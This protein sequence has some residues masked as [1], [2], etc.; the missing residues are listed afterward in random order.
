LAPIFGRYDVVGTWKFHKLKE[1][2]LPS[3]PLKEATMNS[4]RT[5]LKSG[6]LACGVAGSTPALSVTA[7]NELIE[8]N[9]PKKSPEALK[10]GLMTYNLARNWD[11]DTIIQNCTEAKFQHVELRTTHAHGVEVTLNKAERIEVRKRFEDSPLEAISLASAFR[12]HEPDPAVLRENIEGTKEYTLLAA[13]IGALGIRVFPNAVVEGVPMEETFEQIGKALAEV[14]DFAHDHGV[15][16]RVCVHGKGT[17][18]VPY[19]KQMID[20]SGSKHVY[21][22]WN[23]DL[24]DKEGEGF[25]HNFDLVKDRVRGVHMHELWEEEYPYRKFFALMRKNRYDGYLNAEIP[26]SAEPVRL[27]KY[28]RAV[29]LA[30]QNVI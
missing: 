28:Y 25:E 16:I 1:I 19:I 4:R 18:Y 17:N 29:F 5:F 27:M 12:Y 11:I 30:L 23:C 14:G 2:F 21:V 20:Y 22:N 3:V 15:D 26:E 6:L 9:A 13:D 24:R 7:V 10:L 8:E